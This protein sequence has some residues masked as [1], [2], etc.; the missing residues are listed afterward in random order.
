MA[1]HS[2]LET[3]AHRESVT[4]AARRDVQVVMLVKGEQKFVFLYHHGR[5]DEVL[6]K[7]WK[8]A[9]MKLITVCEALMLSKRVAE[10]M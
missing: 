9:A 3:P 5:E 6:R 4:L 7:I 10:L 1:R 2:E 8:F